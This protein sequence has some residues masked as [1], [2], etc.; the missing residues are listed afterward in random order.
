MLDRFSIS[1]LLAS[2]AGEGLLAGFRRS[3]HPKGALVDLADV[4]GEIFVVTSG[5]LRVYLTGEARE[6]TLFHLGPGEIFCMHSGCGIEVVEAAELRATDIGTFEARLAAEP[7]LALGLIAVF[8][9]GMVSMMRTIENLMFFDI[10]RRIARLMLAQAPGD[11]DGPA[12][13]DLG[14]T[15]EEIANL[16]GSSRQATSSALAGL[17]REGLLARP[18]RGRFVIPDPVALKALAETQAP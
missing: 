5:R 11:A 12:T 1:K 9:R 15:V 3:Q 7:T 17:V 10:R 13:V 16:L 14:L 6:I 2:R 18:A 8:G 4:G